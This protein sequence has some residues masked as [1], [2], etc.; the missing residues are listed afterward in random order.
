MRLCPELTKD[1]PARATPCIE[2][3]QPRIPSSSDKKGGYTRFV[4]GGPSMLKLF[5]TSRLLLALGTSLACSAVC[6]QAANS[7]KF[8]DPRT[9]LPA[10]LSITG[11]CPAELAAEVRR[12][13][14]VSPTN[15]IPREVAE[16]IEG[17]TG[18]SIAPYIQKDSPRLLPKPWLVRVME[19]LVRFWDWLTGT[20]KPVSLPGTCSP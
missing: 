20:E 8:T 19:W 9:A 3:R 11:A 10:H 6:A 13:L 1:R 18:V 14:G 12:E 15:P 2:S 17:V 7:E 16:K 5:L 4:P